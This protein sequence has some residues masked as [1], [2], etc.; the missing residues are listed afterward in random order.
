MIQ[1][2][3]GLRLAPNPPYERF[4]IFAVVVVVAVLKVKPPY[5]GARFSPDFGRAPRRGRMQGCMRLSRAT[6][7]RVGKARAPKLGEERKPSRHPGVLSLWLLSLCTSKE[8]VT[9]VQGGAPASK[10]ILLDWPRRRRAQ[11]RPSTS[12]LR[13]AQH[14]RIE[15]WC[16]ERTLHE[17]PHP[18]PS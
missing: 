13:Q 16:M 9:P 14:E 15:K 8:K 4:Y 5:G 12:L 7:C 10:T 18:S 1:P 17:P 3:G 11:P 2:S 6:G